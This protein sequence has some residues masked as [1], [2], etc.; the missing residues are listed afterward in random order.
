VA[1]RLGTFVFV[2]W[3]ASLLLGFVALGA[4]G[5]TGAGLPRGAAALPH[6]LVAYSRPL[7]L[8][9]LHPECPCA[10]ADV[11]ELERLVEEGPAETRWVALF[12]QPTEAAPGGLTAARLGNLRPFELRADVDGRIARAL[13]A[14]RSGALYVFRGDGTLA[15]AG[16]LTEARGHAGPGR[17]RQLVLG[18]LDASAPRTAPTILPVRGCSLPFPTP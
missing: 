8:Y 14:E 10:Q 5:A 9:V 7:A 16:G 6:P 1:S 2:G 17:A 15:F 11:E 12:V 3:L 4:H 13:G 18:A